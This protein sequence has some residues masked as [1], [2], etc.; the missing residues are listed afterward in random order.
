MNKE[1][2]NEFLKEIEEVCKKYNMTISH[3][4]IHG[5]FIIKEF[6]QDSIEWLKDAQLAE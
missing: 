5:E 2:V 4:D 6:N 3:E 1:K